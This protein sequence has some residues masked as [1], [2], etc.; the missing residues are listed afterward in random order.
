MKKKNFI[1]FSVFLAMLIG[2]QA[3]AAGLQFTPEEIANRKKWEHFLEKAK[4][5]ESENV[6]EGI[7]KP[8]KLTMELDG[9]QALGVWKNPSG[10]QQGYK[11]GW[12]YEIAAYKLD[13]YLGLNMIPPTVERTFR[14]R[15]GSLQLWVPGLISE[16]KRREKDIAVPEDKE[17]YRSTMLDLAR[18]FDDLIANVD[19]TQ[20]NICYTEDWRLILIDHSRSFRTKRIYVDQLLYGKNGMRG[21]PFKKLPRAFVDKV[22]TLTEDRIRRIVGDYLT[23]EEIKCV[24][25]RKKLFLKEIDEMI[26]EV[27]E[28]TFLY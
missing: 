11:E 8:K 21:R 5:I 28:D 19:R 27:G 1:F 2:L 12:D 24:I 4:I 22:R 20:Q 17:E 15:K 14:L 7:T 18:A 3:F 13:K 23:T 16:L 25:A 26:K 9:L 10:V 6:G